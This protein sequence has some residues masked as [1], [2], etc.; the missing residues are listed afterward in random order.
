MFKFSLY[1]LLALVLSRVETTFGQSP[2]GNQAVLKAE[3]LVK[4]YT[5]TSD[6]TYVINFWATWCGPCVNELPYFEELNKNYLNQKVKV[7]LVS[8]DFVSDYDSKLVRFVKRKKIQSEVLLLN[9]TKPNEFI[10]KINPQWNGSIPATMIIN[11]AMKYKA[12]F[13]QEVG[14]EFLEGKIKALLN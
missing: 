14:Y 2:K 6:T 11:N 7:I 4:R 3:E 9:E 8:L 13:E 1:L 12:F 5:N 10:D